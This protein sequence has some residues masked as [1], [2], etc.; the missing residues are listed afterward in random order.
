MK[1]K[2]KQNI[3]A[4]KREVHAIE[5]EHSDSDFAEKVELEND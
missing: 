3:V 5:D 4:M 2:I 1:R